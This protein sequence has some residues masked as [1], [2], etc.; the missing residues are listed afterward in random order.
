VTFQ[1]SNVLL[2]KVWSKCGQDLLFVKVWTQMSLAQIL[3]FG[4]W[5][6]QQKKSQYKEKAIDLLKNSFLIIL[7]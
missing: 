1:K 7:N 4:M 6:G 3:M 5:K 2:V